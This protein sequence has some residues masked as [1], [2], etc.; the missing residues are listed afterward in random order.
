V[1][2]VSGFDDTAAR[3]A[4]VGLAKRAVRRLRR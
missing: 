1:L 4:A 3:A 2:N